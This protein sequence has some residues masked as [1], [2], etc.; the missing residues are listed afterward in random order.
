MTINIKSPH[1]YLNATVVGTPTIVDGVV[2]GFSSGNY[3]KLTETFNPTSNPWEWN[4]KLNIGTDVSASPYLLGCTNASG[5]WGALFGINGGKFSC[6]LSSNGTSWNIKEKGQGA[7]TV[8]AGETYYVKFGWTGSEYYIDL[9]TNGID[10]TRDYTLTSTAATHSSAFNVGTTW[11]LSTT[12]NGSI[13]LNESY[14]K[15]NGEYWWKGMELDQYKEIKRLYKYDKPRYFKD[16]YEDWTQPVLTSNNM[17]VED[18]SI[19]CTASS[20]YGNNTGI[21]KIMLGSVSTT[22][23]KNYWQIANSLA[24]QWLQIKFP[25]KLKI[26]GLSVYTRPS[27]NYV[28]TVTAYTDSTK[29]TQIGNS[30]NTKAAVTKYVFLENGEGVVTDTIYI[31]VATRSGK[32]TYYGLQNLQ[33]TAQREK[34]YEVTADG[35]YDRIEFNPITIKQVYKTDKPKYYKYNGG[36]ELVGN[37]V[38]EPSVEKNMRRVFLGNNGGYLTFDIGATELSDLV[39][40]YLS[41]RTGTWSDDASKSMGILGGDAF[42]LIQIYNQKANLG[43]TSALGSYTYSK[44]EDVKW[45]I[46]IQNGVCKI[47]RLN[48]NNEYE[49]DLTFD[50]TTPIS[51][52]V[53][54]GWNSSTRF[55]K[56]G[57]VYYDGTYVNVNG[58]RRWTITKPANYKEVDF[59]F[60]E[61]TSEGSIGGDEFGV[62]AYGEVTGLMN[63]FQPLV[64][65]KLANGAYTDVPGAG[66]YFILY[67]PKPFY[68]RGVT[69]YYGTDED[70]EVIYPKELDVDITALNEN[71]EW[72][73]I[74]NMR[75]SYPKETP[76][77]GGYKE[78]LHFADAYKAYRFEPFMENY[79]VKIGKL[80]IHGYIAEPLTASDDYD[81]KEL[82]PTLVY[83]NNSTVFQQSTAGTYT[84]VVTETAPYE[85]T[86]VGG[87]GGGAFNSSGNAGSAAA[88]NSGSGL[89]VNA[90]LKAGTYVLNVGAGGAWSGWLDANTWGGNGSQ[91]SISKDGVVIATAGGGTG[92]HAWWRSGSA[93]NSTVGAAPTYTD[94]LGVR[95]VILNTQG[96]WGGLAATSSGGASV[97]S[98][99][100]WGK[101]G[102]TRNRNAADNGNAGCIR[103]VRLEK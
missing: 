46:Q 28:A 64:D 72:V 7:T 13:D 48:E 100:T 90:V 52:T 87:G 60:P 103:I 9:S 62:Q 75:K 42:P 23:D 37:V 82:I 1:E 95:D 20:D 94:A 98:G 66:S 36:Q 11:N 63:M 12:F 8:L 5:S 40:L 69:L 83:E 70:G 65:G 57:Y 85:I 59:T 41:F 26:T 21:Y 16:V 38:G 10:Y 14:I 99:T 27:D 84:F 97:I 81:Y 3:L 53:R 51:G 71:G 34:V 102:D 73:Y 80:I 2:S 45:K 78:G 88:G 61:L 33:I 25:Y 91:S 93:H 29:S 22:I 68:Y 35:E 58:E 18:G 17:P 74:S 39:E 31:Y 96:N 6:W 67:S 49:L 54:V 44:Y 55:L 89:V 32:N 30:I 24:E 4:F 43:G 15:I 77:E 76:F 47:Y 50:Y 92:N 101:G 79:G 86:L 19:V 56:S